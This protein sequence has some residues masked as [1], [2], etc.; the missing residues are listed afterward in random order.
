M[1]VL[2]NSW[3]DGCKTLPDPSSNQVQ[4]WS[5]MWHNPE[6]W[7]QCVAKLFFYDSCLDQVAALKPPDVAVTFLCTECLKGFV[8]EQALKQH[9][10]I[11]HGVKLHIASFIDGS[12]ICPACQTNLVT[13]QRVLK[14]VSD[15]RRTKCSNRLL[16]GVFPAVDHEI[17]VYLRG[18][19]ELPKESTG[20]AVTHQCLLLVKP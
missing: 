19:T 20:A 18:P 1:S 15:K 14:H 10:R 17:L 8:T 4:W 11:K 13:R 16:S 5:F 3:P 7:K 6:G 12:G 9:R 2:W